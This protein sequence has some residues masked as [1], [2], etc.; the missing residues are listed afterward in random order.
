[1]AQFRV[2]LAVL[3]LSCTLAAA[4]PFT[5]SWTANLAKSTRDPHHLFQSASLRF[6]FDGALLRLTSGGVNMA[7]KPVSSTIELHVDGKE[8][9]APGAPAGVVVA[10]RRVDQRTLEVVSKRDG[11]VIG[12]GTNQVSS[13]GK[14]LTA[15]VAGTDAKGRNFESVVVFDRD[16]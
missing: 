14:T 7:G 6:E 2:P 10:T 4:D 1:M 9:A 11:R 15:N 8:Y 16:S 13:D 12:R 5:G 3:C